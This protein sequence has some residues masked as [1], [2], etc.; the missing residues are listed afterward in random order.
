MGK[1]TRDKR[2][3]AG[4]KGKVIPRLKK[5]RREYSDDAPFV[6]VATGTGIAPCRS[7]VRSHPGLELNVIHGVPERSA[8]HYAGEFKSTDYLPCLSRET[9]PDGF[10]G[11]V[12]DYVRGRAFPQ[13]AHFYLCGAFEMIS[14][15]SDLLEGRG[16]SP[17]SIF[18]ETYYYG[19]DG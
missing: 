15:V 19:S 2:T 11:R 13:D 16:V 7:F 12:T 4:A 14:E 17:E 3:K 5:I 9:C 18:T 1:R 8:L 6:F 10:R